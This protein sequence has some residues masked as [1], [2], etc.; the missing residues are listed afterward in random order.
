MSAAV[1]DAPPPAA[2]ELERDAMAVRVRADQ[3]T[4]RDATS[5]EA[6]GAFLKTCKTIQKRINETFDPIIKAANDAVK[7]AR[8]MKN[9]HA[10]PLDIAES[11]VKAKMAT[12]AREQ[13]EIRRKAEAEAREAALKAEE[14]RR[15]Q[16]AITYENAGASQIADEILAAP[17]VAPPVVLPPATPKIE[18][19]SMRKSWKFRIVS[20]QIIPREFLKVDEVKLGQ[21][22]RMMKEQASIPGVEFY[23]ED[24][25]SSQSF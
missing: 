24:V 10:S 21:Y 4:I 15:L 11:I 23:A 16:E 19:V 20:E 1:L 17:V 14:E 8:E 5:Y 25:V 12:Y 22:A 13:E 6:A 3:I 18:G 9:Y 2:K 7:K